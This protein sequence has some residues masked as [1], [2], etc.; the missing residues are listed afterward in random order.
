MFVRSWDVKVLFTAPYSYSNESV[1]WDSFLSSIVRCQVR[2]VEYGLKNILRNCFK[3][4]GAV[5]LSM[6]LSVTSGNWDTLWT[7]SKLHRSKRHETN[8]RYSSKK[9][10]FYNNQNQQRSWGRSFSSAGEFWA[11]RRGSGIRSWEL[12]W[13]KVSSPSITWRREGRVREPTSRCLGRRRG[14]WSNSCDTSRRRRPLW[15]WNQQQHHRRSTTPHQLRPRRR[16]R[17]RP[18]ARTT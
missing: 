13:M 12:W 9:N 15:K 14:S 4:V 2:E 3:R 17:R 1:L 10:R 8:S 18:D 6:E 11:A 5:A 16:A 7:A